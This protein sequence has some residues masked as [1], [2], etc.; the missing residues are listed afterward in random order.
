VVAN[1]FDQPGTKRVHANPVNTNGSD[2]GV[3]PRLPNW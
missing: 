3:R 1:G 2:M